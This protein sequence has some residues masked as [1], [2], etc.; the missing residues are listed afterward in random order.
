MQRAFG[1]MAECL[2]DMGGYEFDLKERPYFEE[3]VFSKE[4]FSGEG[5]LAGFKLWL[6]I[7]KDLKKID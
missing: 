3:H 7:K 4:W 2:T 5:Q 1:V 6:P